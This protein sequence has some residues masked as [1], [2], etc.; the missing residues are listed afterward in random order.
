M[1]MLNSALQYASMGWQVFPLAQGAKVPREGSR[2]LHDATTDHQQINEWW[3]AD[4]TANV[5]IRTGIAS[6]LT[7]I[8]VD[9]ETGTQSMLK[10]KHLFPH[11]PTRVI[12][13][14]KGHHLYFKYNPLWNTKVK[15]LDGVD[16]RSEGGY[17]VAPPSIVGDKQYFV[18]QDRDIT[19]ILLPVSPDD[20]VMVKSTE[21]KQEKIDVADRPAWVVEAM[22]GVGEGARDATA[23]SLAGFFHSRGLPKDIIKAILTPFAENCTPPFS[24][25]DLEA[26]IDSVDRYPVKNE[27]VVD[28]P[29]SIRNWI[30]T[31]DGRWWSVD[32]LDN[33]FGLRF[34]HDKAARG[35]IVKTLKETGVIEQ[36]ATTNRSFRYVVRELEPMDFKSPQIQPIL[37]IQWALGVEDHVN[38]YPS[39][40]CVVAGSPNAGKTALML[41]VAYLNQE[42]FPVYYFSSEMGN[43]ELQS[44]IKKF[45]RE[46]ISV[47]DWSMKAFSRNSNFED[48]I[49]PDAINIIDFLEITEAAYNVDYFLTKIS[50][51]VGNGVAIVAIQK[52]KGALLGRGQEYSEQKPRLYLSLDQGQMTIVKG[53]NWA[54]RDIDPTGLYINYKIEDGYKFV[55]TTDWAWH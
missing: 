53:K 17:V 54:K 16:V 42:R 41:N 37:D 26:K 27:P 29:E 46:G 35:S 6:G 10:V 2:G 11:D 5:G 55:P 34:S 50:E 40:I 24:F 39:N 49:V 21:V 43:A 3:G 8:D 48:V 47:D 25:Q 36:H 45:E 18:H 31:T 13:T 32:E 22:Q 38:L 12:K 20:L 52:K 30:E 1:T 14:P 19:P 51:R 28:L 9:G 15:I 33:Q 4:P 44:R 23:T 7:V